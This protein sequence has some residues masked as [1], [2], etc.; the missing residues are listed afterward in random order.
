VTE[1][2]ALL[3]TK[4]DFEVPKNIV[5][6]DAT[7]K[8]TL[9]RFLT[10]Y[11]HEKDFGDGRQQLILRIIEITGLKFSDRVTS[12]FIS[13]P[14]NFW[15][16]WTYD[17]LEEFDLVDLGTRVKHMN[18]ID[19]AQGYILRIK[20]AMMNETDPRKKIMQKEALCKFESAL[21]SNP[22]NKYTLRNYANVLVD[23]ERIKPWDTS[24]KSKYYKLFPRLE[25]AENLL[26]QAMIAD[27]GDGF[28]INQ[29]I[30]FLLDYNNERKVAIIIIQTLHLRTQRSYLQ[31]LHNLCKRLNWM[32][33]MPIVGAHL[34]SS[35]KEML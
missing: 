30:H 10:A 29:Y 6:Q 32:D 11:P 1:I 35:F 24:A 25:L 14:L 12:E 22:G 4:F 31:L 2:C 20:S 18:I 5:D 21:A 33:L 23:L 13:P 15:K 9:K 34:A 7:E 28:T 26:R 27:P 8:W 3:K 19:H 16:D 17:Y